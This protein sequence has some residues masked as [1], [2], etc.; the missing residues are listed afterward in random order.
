MKL[1]ETFLQIALREWDPHCPALLTQGE[2][3]PPVGGGRRG[4]PSYTM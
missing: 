4:L 1:I 2:T 3:P